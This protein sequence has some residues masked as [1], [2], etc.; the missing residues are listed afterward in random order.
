M[1]YG[2]CERSVSLTSPPSDWCA[3]EGCGK[4]HHAKGLCN[5]HYYQQYLRDK[6]ND[7]KPRGGRR[8]NGTFAP[9]RSPNP[10][11]RPKSFGENTQRARSYAP[12]ILD[13]WYGIAMD[14]DASHRDRINAGEKVYDRGYGKPFVPVFQGGMAALD[15]LTEPGLDGGI[16]TPLLRST[17]QDERDREA[18]KRQV[19]AARKNMSAGRPVSDAMALLIA[20]KDEPD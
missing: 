19:D 14:E 15:M 20:V 8:S 6:A 7:P 9:G 12:D 10:G 16:S 3:V 4:P 11:G 17:K 1:A 13:M 5:K 18:L 2:V